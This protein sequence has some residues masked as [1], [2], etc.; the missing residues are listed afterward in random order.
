MLLH[1]CSSPPKD[2]LRILCSENDSAP[3]VGNEG[4]CIEY[5]FDDLEERVLDFNDLQNRHC[6]LLDG[7][8]V[9]SIS[10]TETKKALSE[11]NRQSGPDWR[12]IYETSILHKHALDVLSRL[13][14][15]DYLVVDHNALECLHVGDVLVPSVIR[16][17][18]IP[19]SLYIDSWKE[20]KASR[21]L[22]QS[23]PIQL[24]DDK[25]FDH[26]DKN[27]MD[28]ISTMAPTQ[29]AS[30]NDS[31]GR[32]FF[33]LRV[34]GTAHVPL[35]LSPQKAKNLEEVENKVIPEIFKSL[36]EKVDAALMSKINAIF[37]TKGDEN[38]VT[39][40]EPPLVD[41]I[42]RNAEINGLSL[43]ES[44]LALRETKEAIAFR[45][46]LKDIQ[47]DVTSGDRVRIQKAALAADTA[48]KYINEWTQALDPRYG[49]YRTKRSLKLGRIPVV[50]WL[51]DLFSVDGV[52]VN[53]RILT[54]PEGHLAF[55]AKMYS[56]IT[57]RNYAQ[58]LRDEKLRE[59][60]DI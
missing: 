43:L 40:Q 22:S 24:S 14:V 48:D 50:G 45:I 32:T 54:S 30:S 41:W 20:V 18:E 5:R 33:Y 25:W 55:F 59:L 37:S 53:D 58:I 29:L 52:T 21:S 16:E 27:W 28:F 51:F 31:V 12:G 47:K 49:I 60:F 13:V 4:H 3:F 9:R 57:Q 11:K 8:S 34:A 36:Q 10:D 2:P 17:T 15:Y 19:Q 35:L 7:T 56:E 1:F 6:L 38:V 23:F 44:A 26:P 39:V 46:W 42:I